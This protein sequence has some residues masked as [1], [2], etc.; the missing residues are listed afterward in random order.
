MKQYLLF[1]PVVLLLSS[2]EG[3]QF[4][5]PNDQQ[6]PAYTLGNGEDPVAGKPRAPL[7][8]PPELQAE[9]E[10]PMAGEIASRADETVLSK[11]YQDAVAGKAIA[12]DAKIYPVD[13]AKVF[14]AVVDAMTSLNIPVDSVDSPSG[15][16][17]T[18]WIRRGDASASMFE[19][20]GS[21]SASTP[22]RHRYIVRVYRAKIEGRDE[23]TKLEVRVHGQMAIN[24]SWVNK[25]MKQKVTDQLFV[26]V[27]EQLQRMQQG[28]TGQT[29]GDT[30]Q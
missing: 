10:V 24:R 23:A 6:G 28:V 9:L 5:Y 8:V 14:S 25:A 30:A 1:I 29:V 21:T 17:T 4:F 18:D 27:D 13:A 20:F 2:C 15:I 19:F 11:D 3:K 16:I 12:L 22:T 26:G 7:D